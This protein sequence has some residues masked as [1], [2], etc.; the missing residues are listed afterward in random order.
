MANF[1]AKVRAVLDQASLGQV[2]AGIKKLFS[3]KQKIEVDASSVVSQIQSELS[4]ANFK[5]NVT[6]N[7]TGGSGGSGGGK[8]NISKKL[9]DTFNFKLDSG[10]IATDFGKID[11]AFIRLGSSSDALSKNMQKI[12][13]AYATMNDGS[14]GIKEQVKAY[15]EFSRV[16]PVAQKQI[17]EISKVQKDS[18]AISKE[19]A[20]AQKEVEEATKTLLSSQTKS[21]KIQTWMQ[22]NT[23]AAEA[24]KEELKEIIDQ[25]DGQSDPK[26]LQDASR[27]FAE[28]DSRAGLLGLKT[29]AFSD[30]LKNVAANMIGITSAWQAFQKAKEIISDGVKTVIDLDD[31]MI[32]LKKT[33]TMSSSEL[34]DFYYDAN[35][36]AKELGVTTKQI[37]Q[38]AADWSRMGFNDKASATMMARYSSQFAAISPGMN[39][40]E[41]TTGLVSIMKAYDLEYND[42]L[43]GVM[44]KINIV[45]NNFG[46]TNAE[47]VEGLQKS[48]AA[49]AVTGGTLEDNIALFTA[50]Q[51]VIQNAP[52]VGNAL[53][54][55]GMRIR[56]Y[57]EETE[58]LSEDLANINGDLVELTKTAKNQ[59]GI[60]VFTDETQSEYKALGQYLSEIADIIPDLEVQQKQNLMEKLFGKNRASVGA[61]IIQ[62]IDTYRESLDLMKDSAGNADSEMRIITESISYHVNALKETWVGVAQEVFQ[63]KDIII[64]T[65]ALTG[66]SEVIGGIVGDLGLFGTIATGG[67]ITGI[68]KGFKSLS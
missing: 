11:T 31:S 43:D 28:I 46:T 55:I 18:A 32:D 56:G 52:Q 6:P 54:S 14:K 33:T 41:A 29:N 61:A 57:D 49:F 47:I 63:S 19:H 30:G 16:L 36:Q 1:E 38:S 51:E 67:A 66:V 62:N 9:Q 20:K 27:R 22:K 53:R 7:I 37:I 26:M 4:K 50:G 15:Q 10:S 45:G 65:D 40:E 48:A 39:V 58:M 35:V 8:N 2:D 59:K 68:V 42:V 24:F 44:S 17:S 64:F 23:K 60:S 12:R 13:A 25:L 34:R 21:N 3:E 5:I